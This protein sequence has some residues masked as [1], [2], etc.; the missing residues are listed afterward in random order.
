MDRGA[1]KATII[2]SQS[3]RYNWSVLAYMHAI[4]NNNHKYVS[5]NRA[6]KGINQTLTEL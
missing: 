2:G 6:L 4:N 5:G 1:W 3:L